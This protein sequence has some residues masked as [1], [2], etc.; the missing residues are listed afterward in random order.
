MNRI[1]TLGVAGAVV[2]AVLASCGEPRPED[3]Q[4]GT[5]A[6]VGGVVLRDVVVEAPGDGSYQRGDD[7]VVRL[8]MVG[9]S[10]R[11]DALLG[12]RTQSADQVE[13]RTG[14]DCDGT[15]KTVPRIPV[16][17][18]EVV[19]ESNGV[20]PAYHLRVVDFSDEVVAGATVPLTFIFENAGE[21]TVEALVAED[22]AVPPTSCPG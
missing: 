14:E 12:V 8:A 13:L 22:G 21:A 18:G 5:D 3:D 16:P 7:A 10:E 1:G 11:P 17:T 15:S 19:D 2:A 20:E 9:D 4:S 6:R